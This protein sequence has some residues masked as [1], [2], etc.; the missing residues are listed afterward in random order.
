MSKR[1]HCDVCEKIIESGCY[2]LPSK[3]D[4]DNIKDANKYDVCYSCYNIYEK[5]KAFEQLK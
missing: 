5:V 1:I 4:C 2:S 3:E